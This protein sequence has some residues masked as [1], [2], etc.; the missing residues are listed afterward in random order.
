M[1][2]EKCIILS[3][4]ILEE[5][6]AVCSRAII[7]GEGKI[8]ADGSPEELKSKSKLHGAVT[9]ELVDV[10]LKDALENLEKVQGVDKVVDLSANADCGA[11]SDNGKKIVRV[12]L[13]PMCGK[14]IAHE[15]ASFIH[16]KKW[17]VDG[18]TVEKGD[19]NEVFYN[20]TKGGAA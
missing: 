15:A 4:H 9:L 12:R 5:V 13:M 18:F 20:L 8:V 17:Q 11:K 10:D 3:T 16:Q 1:G 6:E 14:S 2:R 7:I 19:L